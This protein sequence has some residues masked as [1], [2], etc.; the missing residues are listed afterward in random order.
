MSLREGKEAS[1]VSAAINERELRRMYTVNPGISEEG[2]PTVPPTK[3]LGF[4]SM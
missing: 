2:H 3:V 1:G 4:D